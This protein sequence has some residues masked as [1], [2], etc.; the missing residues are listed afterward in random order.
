MYSRPGKT[1]LKKL[2]AGGRQPPKRHNWGAGAAETPQACQA[3][4]AWHFWVWRPSSISGARLFNHDTRYPSI[5][6][7]SAEPSYTLPTRCIRL[8]SR[9]TMSTTRRVQ[10]SSCDECRRSRVACDAGR[11]RRGTE[12]PQGLESC[13]RCTSRQRKCTFEVR[14]PDSSPC[15]P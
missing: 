4:I 14:L 5:K 8:K 12:G 11:V 6:H 1:T 9:F 3:P 2:G 10:F 15:I 13:S 7:R